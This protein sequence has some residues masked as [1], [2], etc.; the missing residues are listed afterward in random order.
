MTDRDELMR[1][2]ELD[3]LVAGDWSRL[4]CARVSTPNVDEWRFEGVTFGCGWSVEV[5]SIPGLFA[6]MGAA[7]CAR[8][9]DFAGIPRGAGSPKNDNRCR[10]QLGL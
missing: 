3:W 9:C 6:R 1:L 4:H 8:C 10:R 2:A 7:R 5:A